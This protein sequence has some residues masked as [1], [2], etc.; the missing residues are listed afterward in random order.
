[1]VMRRISSTLLVSA[2]LSTGG[3]LLPDTA[4]ATHPPRNLHKVGDHWTAWSPPETMPEG[5]QV[6]IIE[7][8]DTLWDLASRFFDNAYL[9]P[10]IWELNRYIEDAHWIY[11]GDPLVVGVEM[12]TPE[13]LAALDGMVDDPDGKEA[14]PEDGLGFL[15]FETARRPPEA[16]GS[17]SDVHCSGY[18]GDLKEEFGYSIIGSEY[19]ALTPDLWVGLK[20]GGEGVYGQIDTERYGVA[21]GDIIYIDGGRAAGLVPGQIFNAIRAGRK[22]FHPESRKVVG[23]YYEQLGR[24]RVLSVQEETAIAEVSNDSCARITVGAHL[25]PFE[26]VPVP[27]GRPGSMRPA[28]FPSSWEAIR[29]GPMIVYGDDGAV[30]LGADQVVFIDQGEGSEVVPGDLFTI[31]RKNKKGL[32]PVILGELAILAVHK[33]TS[34]ARILESRYPIYIGDRLELK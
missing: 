28:N 7:P 26:E 21:P 19:D 4:E 27:L 20:G 2:I 30:S 24:V 11:P 1:M 9:W 10:Q 12:V 5:A 6:H 29:T 14:G 22:I 18:I 3:L 34:V 23:R 33:T 13:Q 16:L 31:Y 15:D 25:R 8:G 17:H 32:P